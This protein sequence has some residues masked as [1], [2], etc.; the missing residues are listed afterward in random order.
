MPSH[1]IAPTI[2]D[3]TSMIYPHPMS[4]PTDIRAALAVNTP[5]QLGEFFE[6]GPHSAGTLFTLFVSRAREAAHLTCSL[7]PAQHP[8]DTP[9]TL[10][11]LESAPQPAAAAALLS[12]RLIAAALPTDPLTPDVLAKL[13]WPTISPLFEVQLAVLW[14]RFEASPDD[15]PGLVGAFDRIAAELYHLSIDD[16]I[17]FERN[18][19]DP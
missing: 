14:G 12:S 6:I 9:L 4:S 2:D 15:R 11:P 3:H 17:T 10:R 19:S 8:E 1:Y 16:L 18:A 5:T 13:P 7:G